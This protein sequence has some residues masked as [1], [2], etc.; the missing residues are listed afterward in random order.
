M[1]I[2][3]LVMALMITAFNSVTYASTR[4]PAHHA[5]KLSRHDVGRRQQSHIAPKPHVGKVMLHSKNHHLMPH[6]G[7]VALN[8]KKTHT[9]PHP[10]KVTLHSKNHHLMPHAGKVTLNGKNTHT[11]PH[12]V[13]FALH[14]KNHHLMPHAG[15]KGKPLHHNEGQHLVLNKPH[16]VEHHQPQN[17][18]YINHPKDNHVPTSPIGHNSGADE[19]NTAEAEHT[20]DKNQGSSQ[21]HDGQH[22]A[23]NEIA[24]VNDDDSK[25]GI[26][27]T[28]SGQQGDDSIV[29]A[30]L[31]EGHPDSNNPIEEFDFNK[32]IKEV[33]AGQDG[34]DGNI[35]LQIA[36]EN[37]E[38]GDDGIDPYPQVD[39]GNKPELGHNSQVSPPAVPVPAALWLF[40][41]GLLGLVGIRRKKT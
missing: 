25:S 41:S 6:P 36:K 23:P 32:D 20:P 4:P 19:L 30:L 29:P 34:S 27:G 15:D 10:V 21:N 33:I 17:M 40:G 31:G 37:H 12:P 13:K 2:G 1:K 3:F 35:Y 22:D 28:D 5:S 39:T 7:K 14:S 18:S 16:V 38:S 9:K 26:P 8:G 11:I 24:Q